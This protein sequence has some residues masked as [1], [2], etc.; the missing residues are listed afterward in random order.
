MLP[1]ENFAALGIDGEYRKVRFLLFI[2][3]D[4]T[5]DGFGP[6]ETGYKADT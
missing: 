1:V 5:A 6:T 3:L 2:T 4:D